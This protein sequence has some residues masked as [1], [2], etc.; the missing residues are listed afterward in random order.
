MWTRFHFFSIFGEGKK[1]VPPVV[2]MA[3]IEAT[4]PTVILALLHFLF[5]VGFTLHF[6]SLFDTF[7]VHFSSAFHIRVS[8]ILPMIF[9]SP[10]H[11]SW[12]FLSLLAFFFCKVLRFSYSFIINFWFIFLHRV[13]SLTSFSLPLIK[14]FFPV[15]FYTIFIMYLICCTLNFSF[16]PFLLFF[17][18][19]LS[20]HVFSLNVFSPLT[21]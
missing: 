18:S 21:P 13:W 6:F 14:H 9:F 3:V 10:F 1:N 2:V 11:I 7:T 15:H 16:F 8:L 20:N 4:H 17:Y 5:S 12:S 19:F